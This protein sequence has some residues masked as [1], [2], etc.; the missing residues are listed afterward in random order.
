MFLLWVIWGC[1]KYFFLLECRPGSYG[2]NCS[3]NCISYCKEKSCD[4][5][6]GEC[7]NGCTPGYEEPD[8]SMRK[9]Y[10]KL[11]SVVMRYCAITLKIT[12]IF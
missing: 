6:S 8:C 4:R 3:L 9:I 2:P 12:K 7:L 10:L 5:N 1:F 11:C